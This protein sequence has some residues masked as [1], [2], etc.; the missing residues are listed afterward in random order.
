MK[1][2]V[3]LR[4]YNSESIESAS[5]L[6]LEFLRRNDCLTS[7]IIALPIRIKRYCVL[8]S[9]HI[10]KD[11]REHFELRI[12]KRFFDIFQISPAILDL[13]F[14]LPLPP[15]VYCSLVDQSLESSFEDVKKTAETFPTSS[16]NGLEQ[17]Q[18]T[19]PE[20]ES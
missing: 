7:G 9:P 10:D 1:L 3:L 18:P 19:S 12:Y 11:S 2:R 8:R 5:H 17:S 6:F 16:E 4:S 13:L 15:G 20:E 14:Q